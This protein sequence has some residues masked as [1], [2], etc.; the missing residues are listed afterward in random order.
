[1]AR[2]LA[3]LVRIPTVNPYSGDPNPAGEAAGQEWAE[4]QMRRVGGRIEFLAVPP[5][6]Y[7]RGGVLGPRQ[8]CWA[9]RRN[10]IG[11]FRFGA[12]TGPVIVLNAHM[13]TVGVSDYEGEPFSGRRDGDAIHGRGA[14]D[15]KGGVVA[16]LF[17]L[18]ALK[19]TRA[20]VN[21]EV[22]FECVVDEE[23][24]GAGA[25]TLA[26]CLSGIRGKYCLVLDGSYGEL[27]TACQGVATAEITVSG[28]A[29]H[30]SSGGVSAVDKILLAKAVLDRLA[31]ERSRTQPGYMI[32]VGALRAG[33]APWTVP[34][35]G[36]LTANINYSREEAVAAAAAGKG[37][38]GALARERLEAL[39]AEA[40]AADP[41]LREHPPQLLWVKDVPPFSSADSPSA[42][43]L[44]D[45]VAAARE[46]CR[47]A[48][49]REPPVGSLHA[50]GDASHLA[51]V[52]RMPVVGMGAGEPG[53][54]HTAAEFN[55]VA[56]VKAVAAAAA[57]TILRLAG[58]RGIG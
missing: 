48:A 20:P 2:A 10:V 19:A 54:A 30:G 6:V 3:D 45:L 33:L 27:Y 46:S 15:C 11:R 21:A 17:A 4:R 26:C 38:C 44:A 34:S 50:W 55:R 53:T 58:G 31:A 12:G 47:A 13:D 16:A 28:R 24:S 23:C 18:E 22:V 5:D 56:N 29:A 41:W 49:G 43:D 8:R 37:F 25:G 9:G 52:G 57:L 14:S 7:R 51:L 39:L 32:N 35:H 1:M 42:S 36:W 40:A